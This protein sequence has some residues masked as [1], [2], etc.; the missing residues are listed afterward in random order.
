MLL[1]F[2][3]ISYSILKLT[4]QAYVEEGFS[5]FFIVL[6]LSG[7]ENI[8]II[9]IKLSWILQLFYQ[10]YTDNSDQYF[11]LHCNC[12]TPP[13]TA[14]WTYY[15]ITICCIFVIIDLCVEEVCHSYPTSEWCLKN[16]LCANPKPADQQAWPFRAFKCCY[17]LQLI[18]L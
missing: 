17:R 13:L 18:F 4:Q 15:Y 6:P 12:M 8:I 14:Q 16:I 3:I 5:R 7:K 1:H 10:T 11:A 9:I 2:E